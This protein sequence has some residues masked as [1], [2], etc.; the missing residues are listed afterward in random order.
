MKKS[1]LSLLL[2]L[3]L[4]LS[5]AVQS[6]LAQSTP[7]S[8]FIPIGS[9]YRTDTLQRFAQTAAQRDTNGVVACTSWAV[10]RPLPCR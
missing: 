1:S 2:T 4:S 9:D 7:L 8:T 10:T 5:F 6:A 3:V